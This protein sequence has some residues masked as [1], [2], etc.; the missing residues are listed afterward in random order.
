MDAALNESR[1]PRM[2]FAALALILLS[3]GLAGAHRA[4]PAAQVAC[5]DTVP[6]TG[7]YVNGSYGFSVVIPGNAKGFWNSAK[8]VSAAD[9]CTCMSDHG[10]IIPLGTEPY[11]PERHI[12]VHAAHAA[13]LDDRTAQRAI[14]RNLD[15]IRERSRQDSVTVLRQSNLLLSGLKAR[16]AV[17]RYFDTKLNRWTIEDMVEALRG[18]E[19][20]YSVYLRTPDAAYGQDVR[21]FESL[22]N[23]FRLEKLR[24]HRVRPAGQP[25]YSSNTAAI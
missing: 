16:R 8:C 7:K 21:V 15:S 25:A 24:I 11:E 14:D 13:D 10:R 23:S 19:I 22:V 20:E 6:S 9:G 5:P 12:E 2:T 4:K 3:A 1:V 17:V 18:G